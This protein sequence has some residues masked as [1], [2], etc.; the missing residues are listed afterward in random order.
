RITVVKKDGRRVPWDRTRVLGGLQRACYKRPVPDGE[1]E[2]L[3]EEI[4][5]EVFSTFDREAST[6]EVGQIVIDRLRR[7]DQV[8]YVRFASVY[9]QFR[10]LDDLMAEVR[11]VVESRRLEDPSQGRL[12]ADS[13]MN[14]PAAN[15]PPAASAAHDSIANNREAGTIPRKRGRP[16]KN[17][18]G[19]AEPAAPPQKVDQWG[20]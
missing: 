5:E 19:A 20:S 16:R 17:A 2:R 9:R 4:E 11:A 1:L 10:T 15:P 14:A 13:D 6:A 18:N 12:F 7:L 3:A 8:A